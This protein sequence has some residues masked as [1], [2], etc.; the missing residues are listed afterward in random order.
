MPEYKLANLEK[1]DAL[2]QLGDQRFEEAKQ[3]TENA[4][5]YVF[6]TVLFAAVLFF[7][8][9]SMRF[10]WLAMR[11]TV[12]GLSAIFLGYG[13]VRSRPCRPSESA[14]EV[15]RLDEYQFM[16]G[17]MPSLSCCARLR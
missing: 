12:L 2:E 5:R 16:G 4:D 3:A 10:N 15:S 8:G 17:Q 7:A 1:A 11:L 13:L 9:I 14:A 6:V